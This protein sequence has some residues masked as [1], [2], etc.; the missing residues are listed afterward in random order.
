MWGG[1]C[2]CRQLSGWPRLSPPRSVPV[3]RILRIKKEPPI[4]QPKEPLVLEADLTEF[5]VAN[6]RFPSEVLNMLKN[7]Q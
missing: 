3:P 1:I 4:L 5:D 6:S 7:I 2:P